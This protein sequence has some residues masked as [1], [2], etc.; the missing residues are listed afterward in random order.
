METGAAGWTTI[1]AAATGEWGLFNP[2]GTAAQP[3]D[4]STPAPG[5]QCFI[6]GQCGAGHGTCTAACG[7]GEL[8][9]N[10]VDA[11]TVT[12]VSP[13]YDVSAFDEVTV[14]YDRWYSNN[15]GGDPNNDF[16]VVE[17]SNDG[18][19]S[20]TTVE[21]TS[22]S[23]AAWTSVG[24]DVDAA[25]GT[26]GQVQVRFLASDLNAG[27]LVE[28]GVDEF[29]ILA[30]VSGP[31]ASLET[32]PAPAVLSLEQNQP[33]P[34]SP[35]TSIRFAVPQRADVRLAVYDVQGRAVRQLAAGTREAGRYDVTWNGRD[36][37]GNRVAA[38]V[39]FYRL[40][41]GE[42]TLTRKMTVLK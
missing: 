29:R 40:T 19:S 6:T 1:D 31:V 10:D 33:N 22:V 28:A 7:S 26:P 18:G 14:K 35:E 2:V 39:Y 23:A 30:A 16:W 27:S 12:L 8:G 41:A 20:W 4:D 5:T 13:V 38:G 17:I 15:T 3:E 32:V 25:F 36:A 34:F 37:Q 42:E 24:F 9:C 11:G 21:N